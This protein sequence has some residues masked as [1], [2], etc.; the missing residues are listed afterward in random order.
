MFEF[1]NRNSRIL[2][3]LA[4]VDSPVSSIAC[5]YDGSHN[6]QTTQERITKIFTEFY[7]HLYSSKV[8]YTQELP[9][10][11]EAAVKALVVPITVGMVM[12]Q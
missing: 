3:Y 9:A 5:I 10:L 2:A 11:T 7:T 8:N 6:L 12:L 1:G 4:R